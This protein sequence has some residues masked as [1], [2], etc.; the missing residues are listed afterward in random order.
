MA[1]DHVRHFASDVL[2]MIPVLYA[3]LIEKGLPR[4]WLPRNVTCFTLLHTI[5]CI[6]K[7]GDM[8]A[9]VRDRLA[10]LINKHANFMATSSRKW[11]L[12]IYTILQ[13]TCFD[14]RGR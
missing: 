13:M 14:L 12:I 8:S 10:A 6:L 11:K 4:G 1:S 3:F 5:L 9:E 2:G 7:R